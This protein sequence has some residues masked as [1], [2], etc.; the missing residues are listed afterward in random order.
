MKYTVIKSREQYNQYCRIL[1]ELVTGKKD[2][3][4]EEIE[5]LTLLMEQGDETHN[6][7]KTS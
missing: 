5:L 1:E 4:E 7:S 3:D 2:G 6:S